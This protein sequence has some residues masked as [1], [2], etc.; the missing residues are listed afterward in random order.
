MQVTVA[1]GV[2]VVVEQVTAPTFGS[3]I[4]TDV[5]VWAP[6]LVTRNE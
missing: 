2:S 1:P 5:R 3:E 4:A 6:V